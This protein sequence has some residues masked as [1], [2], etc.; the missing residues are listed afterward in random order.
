MPES[1]TPVELK[2]LAKLMLTKDY[3]YQENHKERFDNDINL[4]TPKLR[5]E[6]MNQI[7]NLFM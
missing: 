1:K 5:I 3:I 2:K 6:V 7:L 4:L